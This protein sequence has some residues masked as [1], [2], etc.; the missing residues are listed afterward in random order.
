MDDQKK[1]AA[2]KLFFLIIRYRTKRSNS[3]HQTEIVNITFAFW[4]S[5]DFLMPHATQ[6]Q[7][8]QMMSTRGVVN[9]GASNNSKNGYTCRLAV[10]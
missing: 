5:E 6:A 7:A 3:L 10:V 8:A 4:W 9:S 1:V 2:E